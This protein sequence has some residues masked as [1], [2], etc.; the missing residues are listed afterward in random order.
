[1][2]SRK[3]RVISN[4]DLCKLDKDKL[5]M[6]NFRDAERES[7]GK[8]K[9]NQNCMRRPK[10]EMT[11]RGTTGESAPCRQRE[12]RPSVRETRMSMDYE[13]WQRDIQGKI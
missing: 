3:L 2:K 13:S 7:E 12:M 1:M 8:T 4:R 9:Y 6:D 10:R 11:Q 5:I